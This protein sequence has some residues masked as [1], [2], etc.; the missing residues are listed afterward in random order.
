M[1]HRLAIMGLIGWMVLG[2]GLTACK[3]Q[4]VMV[5][6]PDR[7]RAMEIKRRHNGSDQGLKEPTVQL[8]RSAEQLEALG[9]SDLAGLGIDFARES[10][11]LLALGEMPTSG[12]W[13]RITGVQ[14]KGDVLYVQGLA[15]RPH[16][17]ET[18]TPS[19]TYPYEAVVI[20]RVRAARVR[21]E[22]ES[23]FGRSPEQFRTLKID[24]T[25]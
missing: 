9:S 17:S 5:I 6:A 11:V 20:K 2:A 25:K 16:E 21:S 22:I 14:R 19:L 4:Q 24:A 15:N 8:I 12:F 18:V 13:A 7:P 3:P 10:L 23:V 1:Q